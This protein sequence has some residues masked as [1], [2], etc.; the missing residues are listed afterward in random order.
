MSNTPKVRVSVILTA[1]EDRDAADGKRGSQGIGQRCS[2]LNAHP[3]E[4]PAAMMIVAFVTEWFHFEWRILALMPDKAICR[5]LR[6]SRVGALGMLG[7]GL[8]RHRL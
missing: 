2:L 7:H 5:G 6:R 1:T 3:R 8:R 4:P